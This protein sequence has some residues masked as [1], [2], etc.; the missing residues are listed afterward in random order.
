MPYSTN[1][2]LLVDHSTSPYFPGSGPPSPTANHWLS[3]G[4]ESPTTPLARLGAADPYVN[5]SAYPQTPGPD[6]TSTPH[7]TRKI[8]PYSLPERLPSKHFFRGGDKATASGPAHHANHHH[9]HWG[10]N[11]LSADV[12]IEAVFNPLPAADEGPLTYV[13]DNS[14]ARS[15]AQKEEDVL[16]RILESSRGSGGAHGTDTA[17]PEPSAMSMP[18]SHE[19][20][21]AEDPMTP[22]HRVSGWTKMKARAQKE[23]DRK[24]REQE[25]LA[26]RAL[27][28]A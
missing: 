20:S 8:S 9:H 28:E 23:R 13:P 17:E 10:L 24:E 15:R 3:P 4:L 26:G 14:D 5:L 16:E 18:G 21:A 19:S 11:A 2:A 22:P 25:R 6:L 7:R 27:P 12:I 1:Q